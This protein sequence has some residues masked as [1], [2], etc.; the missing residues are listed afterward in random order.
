VH[1]FPITEL[2]GLK[3]AAANKLQG[4]PGWFVGPNYTNLGYLLYKWVY[5]SNLFASHRVFVGVLVFKD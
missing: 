3:I 2:L 5:P 4:S 1:F